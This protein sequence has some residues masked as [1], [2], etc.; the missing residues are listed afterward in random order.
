MRSFIVFLAAALL[1]AASPVSANN[2][3]VGERG[4]RVMVSQVTTLHSR[5]G[6]ELEDFVLR[7]GVLFRNY[8]A[9][10]SY[11]AC[12]LILQNGEGRWAIPVVTNHSQ[13]GCAMPTPTLAGYSMSGMT[14]HSHPTEHT[15][16]ANAADRTFSSTRPGERQ[17]AQR[18]QRRQTVN[19][20]VFSAIDYASGPGYLVVGDKVMFQRG[21]GT[22][23]DVGT[24]PA[25]LDETSPAETN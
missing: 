17:N 2:M 7:A 8:T 14:I 13:I 20:H 1:L 16:T 22:E 15:I 12:G 5:P 6:E 19:P 18:Q 21:R 24:L 10:M 9:A 11:E 25:T 3:V 4:E 23:R